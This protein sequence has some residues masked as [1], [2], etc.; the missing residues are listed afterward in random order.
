MLLNPVL[1]ISKGK[2]EEDVSPFTNRKWIVIPK[3]R[4]SKKKQYRESI[5]TERLVTTWEQLKRRCVKVTVYH[6]WSRQTEI[7]VSSFLSDDNPFDIKMY[8]KKSYNLWNMINYNLHVV[9]HFQLLFTG[10]L[11][12]LNENF[13]FP[14]YHFVHKK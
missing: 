12:R 7:F 8:P 14:T 13:S 3:R 2:K 4:K 6:P 5:N 9:G 1:N 10:S 11:S